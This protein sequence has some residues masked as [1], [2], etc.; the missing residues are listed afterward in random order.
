[1]PIVLPVRSPEA[2]S[3]A[4]MVVCQIIWKQ[5]QERREMAWADESAA[6]RNHW[7]QGSKRHATD[8]YDMDAFR[9][10]SISLDDLQ[11]SEGT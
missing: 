9:D 11:I 3:D 5:L 1:M 4:A 7:N 8:W 2:G 10:G 6:N